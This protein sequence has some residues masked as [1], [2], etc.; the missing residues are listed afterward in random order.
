MSRDVRITDVNTANLTIDIQV[1]ST[2]ANISYIGKAKPSTPTSEAKWQILQI[3]DTT[4][5]IFKWAK[6]SGSFD[7]VWDDRETLSYP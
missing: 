6:G 4:G 3:D 1:K 2:D 7:N 5:S